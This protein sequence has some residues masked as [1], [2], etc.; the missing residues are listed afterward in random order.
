MCPSITDCGG[1]KMIPKQNY[2]TR[3][4]ARE[5]ECWHHINAN[6]YLQNKNWVTVR[7]KCPQINVKFKW[8]TF[9]KKIKNPNGR[10]N[11]RMDGRK[12]GHPHNLDLSG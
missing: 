11:E 2:L 5:R 12:D 8:Y 7:D 4:G 1:I 10:T 6:V 3:P 9:F